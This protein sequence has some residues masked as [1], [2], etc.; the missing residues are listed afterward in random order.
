MAIDPRRV[1]FL[2]TLKLSFKLRIDQPITECFEPEHDF[3]SQARFKTT[4]AI[5]DPK[6]NRTRWIWGSLF[7]VSDAGK[8][9]A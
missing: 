3:Y 1:T 6:R 2:V 5:R 9:V 4:S 7:A 8:E